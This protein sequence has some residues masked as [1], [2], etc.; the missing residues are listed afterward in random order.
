MTS[1]AYFTTEQS[2][3]RV[4]ESVALYA[5]TYSFGSPREDLF[6]PI[7]AE[8]DKANG[9]AGATVGFEF[10]EDGRE[11]TTDGTALGIVI[12]D[13]ET[14][15]DTYYRIPEG[16]SGKMTLYVALFLDSEA[17]EADYA[18][19]VTDLPFYRGETLSRQGLNV[20]ELSHYV[21]DEIELNSSK[22][23]KE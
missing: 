5:I 14:T 20:Y 7:G 21:T 17:P 4:S 11:T 16:S 15:E 12:S 8:R 22:P 9:T 1:S 19:Q 10:L 23:S 6:M 3:V 18:L 13:L 2:A